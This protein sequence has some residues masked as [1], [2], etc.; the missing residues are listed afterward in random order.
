MG[1]SCGQQAKLSTVE[2]I[3][4][5]VLRLPR[6]EAARLAAWF[7]ERDAALWDR[8]IEED[9]ASDRAESFTR[10]P[11]GCGSSR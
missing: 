4:A 11:G 1:G 5:A 7:A 9:A 2:E 6:A 3:Q 10:R 8:Q